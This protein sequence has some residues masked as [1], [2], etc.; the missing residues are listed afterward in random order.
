MNT[1]GEGLKKHIE[2]ADGVIVGI[3]NEFAADVEG[4]AT[5]SELYSFYKSCVS[6]Y[7][8]DISCDDVSSNN[9]SGNDVSVS[10]MEQYVKYSIYY[11]ELS[12]GQNSTI[13][14]Y[15]DAYKKIHTLLEN[16]RY[17][18]LTTNT[19]DIIYEGGFDENSI[20]APCGSILRLQAGCECGS[21]CQSAKPVLEE[22]YK[23][24][25]R[26]HNEKDKLT[27]D[28]VSEYLK[29][30]KAIIPKCDS[31]NDLRVFNV[32]GE[33]GYDERGYMQQW[34]R[35]TGWLQLT[36]NKKLVLLEL[37]VGFDVP[38]VIRWP[39]EKIAMLNYKAWLYRVNGK[40]PQLPSE[41]KDKGTSV[42][43]N[44]FE[45]INSNF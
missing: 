15:I 27:K 11:S 23:I 24:L 40:L 16:K 18:V 33:K 28:T 38:T 8:D 39:F 44:S 35:Y 20:A 6:R 12:E 42:N 26:L 31:C 7:T 29:E 3:G 36:L 37:G 14:K 9:I 2:E 17:F 30:I 41:L 22:I 1:Y 4:I 19:D 45:F 5:G 32:H 34:E 43:E 21:F 10:D 13:N 25:T